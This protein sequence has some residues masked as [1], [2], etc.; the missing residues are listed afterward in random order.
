SVRRKVHILEQQS[1]EFSSTVWERC[2]TSQTSQSVRRQV[3]ILEQQSRE[4]SSTVWERRST[5]QTSQSKTSQVPLTKQRSQ[6]SFTQPLLKQLQTQLEKYMI[7]T[8]TYIRTVKEFCDREPRWTLQREL[9]IKKMKEI[10]SQSEQFL[11]SFKRKSQE[12]EFG[13]VL[14]DTL[15]GL[16]KLQHFLDAVERLAVT[17]LFV[18]KDGL[19]L[20]SWL[21]NYS[22]SFRTDKL[23]GLMYLFDEE[24]QE[25]IDVYIGCRS[26]MLRFLSDLE[27]TA[28]QL[29]KMKK[30]SSI[31]NVVGS[32]VGAVGGILSIVGLALAPVTAGVS[33][34]L[35][36]TGVGLGVTSGVNGLVTGI[37]EIA[38][39]KHQRERADYIFKNFE[40]DVQKVL[41]SLEQA[42][43]SQRPGIHLGQ[44]S[45]PSGV[46]T[47]F[48][49]IKTSTKVPV[50]G[51]ELAKNAARGISSPLAITKT[52]R[53]A[54][55]AVNALF[56]GFD[57]AFICKESV[58][59]ANGEKSDASRLIRSRSALWRSEIESWGKM[60]NSLCT[61]QLVFEEK[62]KILEQEFNINEIMI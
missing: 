16:G 47:H 11:G 62:L 29:D 30:G 18:F 34:T 57:I 17:S 59:L 24:A 21:H 5:S 22:L 58:S 26:R 4:F 8:L 56:I 6:E 46:G 61:E 19:Y 36:L 12:K 25:F 51:E 52:A 40:E 2:S 43:S 23:F 32:S 44:G 28:V 55:L 3:H 33:L 13:E 38:I 54:G 27:E 37:T 1:R 41:D 50:K 31:S 45:R 14:E 60:C 53:V 39:N 15:E 49:R 7:D 10:K 9:E 20:P 42:A 35:T 48:D